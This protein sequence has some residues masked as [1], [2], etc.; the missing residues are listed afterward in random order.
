[1][2][3]LIHFIKRRTMN[4]EGFTLLE[5]MISMAIFAVG[6][7]GMLTLQTTSINSNTLA[8]DVQTNT[9]TAMAE[10]E[11]LMATDFLDQ[12][13]AVTKQYTCSDPRYKFTVT[14]LDDTAIPGSMRVQIDME[15]TPNGTGAIAL[16]HADGSAQSITLKIVKPD[17]DHVTP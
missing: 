16:A 14:P 7:L 8:E 1:M 17:I 4:S 15:F 3:R 12:R 11:G 9:V 5:A 13:L 10:I 2:K 6:I